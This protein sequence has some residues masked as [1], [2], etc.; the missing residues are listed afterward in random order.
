MKSRKFLSGYVDF[1]ILGKREAYIFKNE[2][3]EK[4]SQ[5]SFRLMVKEGDNWKEV[6]VFWVREIKQKEPEE[7]VFDMTG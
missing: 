5:P 2:K 3:R 1:G 4:E 7:E 6:G